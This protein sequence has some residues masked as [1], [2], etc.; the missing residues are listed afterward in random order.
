MTVICGDLDDYDHL[1][2]AAGAKPLPHLRDPALASLPLPTDDWPFLYQQWRRLSPT[3]LWGLLLMG[4]IGIAWVW[5]LLPKGDRAARGQGQFF[6]LGVSFLLVEVKSI[7]QLALVWGCTWKVSAIVIG[8]IMVEILLANLVVSKFRISR[9]GWAYVLL[10]ASLLASYFF[11]TSGVASRG[12][13]EGRVWPTLVLLIPLFFAG[14]VF[15][16]VFAK[17]SRWTPPLVGISW[18][19]CSEASWSTLP[20]SLDSGSSLFLR[21]QP[22]G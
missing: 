11:D 16:V 9:T 13:L 17:A 4:A 19:G 18:A 15:A 5:L 12:F 21:W 8:V 6:W 2:A 14:I 22:M 1:A 10:L 3:F 7:S 20:W